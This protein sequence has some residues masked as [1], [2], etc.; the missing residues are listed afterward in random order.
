MLEAKENFGLLFRNR[1]RRAKR[2]A[3]AVFYAKNEKDRKRAYLDLLAATNDTLEDARRVLK[4]LPDV[5][6]NDTMAAVRAASL[7]V[8]LRRFVQLGERV[9]DQTHRRVVFGE[10]VPAEEKLVSIFEDHADIIVK[11]RRET[12][13]GHKVC[14]ASGASNLILDAVVLDGNPADSTLAVEM[15]ERQEQLYGRVPRQVA[16]D[17]GFSSRS[18][19]AGI[20]ELGVQDVCFSKGRGLQVME[21]VKSAWVYAKLRDFRAGIEGSISFLKRCFGLARCTW[22]GLA[23]FQAYVWGS[24]VTAN[25]LV[26]ARHVLAA[27]G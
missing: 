26:L 7:T 1:T 21:M 24:I 23:S 20:K 10:R 18:N 8:Q 12:L 2:R 14:L 17:G 11:D 9:E 3:R 27:P 22:R 5:R 16:F 6:I 4:E 25:L 19:L 15:V 13:F